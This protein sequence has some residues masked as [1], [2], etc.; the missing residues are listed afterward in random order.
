MKKPTISIEFNNLRFLLR[1]YRI[2]DDWL[3]IYNACNTILNNNTVLNQ[4]SARWTTST[5]T[6][7]HVDACLAVTCYQTMLQMGIAAS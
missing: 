2:N 5:G 4:R 6:G 3:A 7:K 1:Y